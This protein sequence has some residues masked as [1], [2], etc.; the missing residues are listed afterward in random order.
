MC[1]KEADPSRLVFHHSD[2]ATKLFVVGSHG[3]RPIQAIVDEVAK[4]V[5]VCRPCHIAHH[6]PGDGNKKKVAS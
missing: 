2:P 6:R 3:G 5:L 1:H 4:C